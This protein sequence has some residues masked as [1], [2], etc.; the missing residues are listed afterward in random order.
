MIGFFYGL[1]EVWNACIVRKINVTKISETQ[2]STDCQTIFHAQLLW[3]LQCFTHLLSVV[4]NCETFRN[5]FEHPA[6]S[7]FSLNNFCW[8]C[9]LH[10]FSDMKFL[11]RVVL[12]FCVL[13]ELRMKCVFCR[14]AL[15]WTVG[16]V[17]YLCGSVKNA[18]TLKRKQEWRM[19]WSVFSC[20]STYFAFVGQ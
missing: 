3:F 4:G 7:L 12:Q 17:V 20:S 5:H 15:S 10:C 19:E 1:I 6:H 14:I 18:Q 8:R 2:F 9:F 13:V 16:A 11:T